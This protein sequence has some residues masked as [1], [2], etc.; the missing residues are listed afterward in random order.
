M[1]DKHAKLQTM[2]ER[3][4]GV[5]IIVELHDHSESDEPLHAESLTWRVELPATLSRKQKLDK[6]RGIVHGQ[7]MVMLA[8]SLPV[9]GHS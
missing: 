4:C 8:S 6:L 9:D 7:L 1:S 2:L 3:D 5:K